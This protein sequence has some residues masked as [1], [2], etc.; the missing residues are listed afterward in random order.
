M[1][2]PINDLSINNLLKSKE[3][4]SEMQL[5][6][7]LFHTKNTYTS[8]S[9]RPQGDCTVISKSPVNLCEVINNG[10][11]YLFGGISEAF[12]DRMVLHYDWREDSVRERNRI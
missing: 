11:K 6:S 8:L 5:R 9:L 3:T 4:E 12:Y 7:F 2:N 10:K 1:D